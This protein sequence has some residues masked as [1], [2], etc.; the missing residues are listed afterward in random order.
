MSDFVDEGSRK[1]VRKY[2]QTATHKHLGTKKIALNFVR[3]YEWLVKI[4]KGPS[5]L[6]TK[7]NVSRNQVTYNTGS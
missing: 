5:N 7:S 4:L 6:V 2:L 3:Y 1:K